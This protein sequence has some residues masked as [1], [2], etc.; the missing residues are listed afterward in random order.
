MSDIRNIPLNYVEKKNLIKDYV[1]LNIKSRKNFTRQEKYLIT[2]YY[3]KLKDSGYFQQIKQ[4]KNKQRRIVGLRPT[5]RIV[6]SKKIKEKGLPRLKGYIVPAASKGQKVR[7][8]TILGENYTKLYFPF[9][10][11]PDFEDEQGTQIEK[12]YTYL[13]KTIGKTFKTALEAEY[14][15]I[16]LVSN[17]ELGQRKNRHARA[18]GR[19]RNGQE[20]AEGAD[21]LDRKLKILA[22]ELYILLERADSS[23]S[24]ERLIDENLDLVKGLYF[25]RFKNQRKPNAKE[26]KTVRVKKRGKS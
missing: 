16:V 21:P 6:R 7:N 20:I 10:F 5:S 11:A 17:Y 3:N 24:Y 22:R 19:T 26:K 8:R 12:T 4:V 9:N 18:S 2:Y 23:Y 14:F 15:T 1:D 25:Y 13:K